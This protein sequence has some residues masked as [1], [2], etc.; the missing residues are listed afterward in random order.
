MVNYSDVSEIEKL[1]ESIIDQIT[2]SHAQ[3]FNSFEESDGKDISHQLLSTDNEQEKN[4][5]LEALKSVEPED[6]TDLSPKSNCTEPNDRWSTCQDDIVD[7]KATSIPGPIIE[8]KSEMVT[9]RPGSYSPV[10]THP[11][12]PFDEEISDVQTISAPRNPFDDD[13]TLINLPRPIQPVK[14]TSFIIRNSQSV[15]SNVATDAKPLRYVSSQSTEEKQPTLAAATPYPKNLFASTAPNSTMKPVTPNYQT[16]AHRRAS[17]PAVPN[18]PQTMQ[19]PHRT[20][21]LS[22]PSIDC[23][24]SKSAAASPLH[25]PPAAVLERKDLINPNV[26]M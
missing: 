23:A 7:S 13:D 5:V 18:P 26:I 10:Q 21:M 25:Q 22:F 20:S 9:H 11:K 24:P 3:S 17:V 16:L 19:K 2:V 14:K 12:N 6:S 15:V 4:N 1:L 8:S